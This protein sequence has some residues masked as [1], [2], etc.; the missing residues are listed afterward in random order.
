MISPSKYAMWGLVIAAMVG[1][2][3]AARAQTSSNEAAHGET[4]WYNRSCD[5]CHS[6]GGGRR[7]GP[8]LKGVA[9]R[10]S[11][12]WLMR[13]LQDTRE[14]L[15]SDSTAMGMMADYHGDHMPQQRL[16]PSDI[17]ALLAY[18]SSKS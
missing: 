16:S 13:W 7:A 4:L 8:D 10:R 1:P 12:A 11:R 14:M 18:I 5:S 15:E 2:S 6:I 9:D 17:N 3:W